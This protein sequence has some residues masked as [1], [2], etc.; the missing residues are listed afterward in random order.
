[1]DD[2]GRLSR[3]VGGPLTA[4]AEGERP[5]IG[6]GAED[7]GARLGHDLMVAERDRLEPVAWVRR[8]PDVPPSVD[9][10]ASQR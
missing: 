9:R 3:R 10:L 7:D 1:M 4:C 5:V 2:Y 6:E 8:D